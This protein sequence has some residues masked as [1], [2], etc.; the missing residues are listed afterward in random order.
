LFPQRLILPDHGQF[1]F[2]TDRLWMALPIAG[3]WRGLPHYP[4]STYGQKLPFW[5]NGY[6]PH[7]ESRPNL[8]VTGRRIDG[9][10]EPLQS[11]GKGFGVWTK[12]DQFIMTGINFPTIGCWEITGR[13]DSD[14]LT[15]V[16]WLAP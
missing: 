2:G 11:D 5:R 8:T 9:P 4:D 15:F 12:D 6:D 1:W 13:Y 10:S 3:T 16:I 14:E 7:T